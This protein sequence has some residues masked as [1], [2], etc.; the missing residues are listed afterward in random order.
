MEAG[1][2]VTVG[3][4]VSPLAQDENEISKLLPA[5]TDVNPLHVNVP[6]APIRVDP[7]A[8]G[9]GSQFGCPGQRL[10]LVVPLPLPPPL[11]VTVH[12]AV[13]GSPPPNW[14]LINWFWAIIPLQVKEM[15]LMALPVLLVITYNPELSPPVPMTKGLV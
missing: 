7:V 12:A 15:L 13:L 9:M 14:Q 4:W 10:Y 8:G 2:G 1:S 5:A 6:V 11:E 3:V